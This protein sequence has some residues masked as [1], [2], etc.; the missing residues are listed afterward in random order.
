MEVGTE[1]Y[2][3]HNDHLGT[4]QKMTAV[5]GAVV[6][7]AQYEAF[8]KASVDEGCTIVN[9][10]R[11]PGQY[12]DQETNLYYNR[13]R[14]YDPK[15]GRYIRVDPIG[16][17]G[18][19]NL[20]NYTKNNSINRIDP[21]GLDWTINQYYK[22]LSWQNYKHGHAP[23]P[24]GKDPW[25]FNPN[26]YYPP[27]HPADMVD[28]YHS[29]EWSWEAPYLPI[30]VDPYGPLRSPFDKS[31]C[32]EC[33]RE[34]WYCRYG[35][36]F[37]GSGLDIAGIALTLTGAGAVPGGIA[38]GASV[39]NSVIYAFVC[40]E[41]PSAAASVALNSLSLTA[42]LVKEVPGPV[43]IGAAAVDIGLNLVPTFFAG[44]CGY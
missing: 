21:F 6:W 43:G 19:I 29:P 5:N 28:P 32:S 39:V 42:T 40:A 12:Y 3:Y 33:P 7:G 4:P 22:W 8:G 15:I 37:I 26:D 11:F 27:E 20:F 9:N 2:F 44:P 41:F 35:A 17:M 16:F 38:Y 30:G 36:S 31:S 1:Y 23:A 14:F 34:G 24:E 10:L 13:F 25:V 18:G